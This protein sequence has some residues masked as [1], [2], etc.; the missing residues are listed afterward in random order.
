MTQLKAGDPAPDFELPSGQGTPIRLSSYRGRSNVI[1]YFYPRDGTSVC[2]AE[3][4]SFRDHHP[5]IAA[6]DAEVLGVSVDSVDSHKKWAQ[7]IGLNYPL[8]SD[9]D[10]TVSKL[11]GVLGTMKDGKPASQRVTFLIDKQG[12]IKEVQELWDLKTPLA[13]IIDSHTQSVKD[14]V[15]QMA[16]RL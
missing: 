11:Y 5:T 4:C 6:K 9:T 8:L 2:T 12:I 1:L 14:H 7:E 13:P 16:Q 15:P 10:G 3:A